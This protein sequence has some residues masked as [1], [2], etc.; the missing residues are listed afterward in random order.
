MVN[1]Q[2]NKAY[3]DSVSADLLVQA[4]SLTLTQTATTP[5]VELTIVLDS[6]DHI[7]SLN[8]QFRQIDAPTDVLSFPSGDGIEDP[9]SSLIYLGD[10]VISVP[11]AQNQAARAGHSLIAELQLLTIHGVLHLI[12]YDH[13]DEDQKT[14]MWQIQADI[15]AAIGAEINSLPEN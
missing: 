3:R 8:N 14:A 6:N 7:Q 4:A 15:L 11:T 2:I 5:E 10:I 9:D 13:V 12:G 1:L